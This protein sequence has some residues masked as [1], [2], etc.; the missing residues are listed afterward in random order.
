MKVLLIQPPVQ[1]F[2]DTDVRLQPI[3]LA[4]LKAAVKKHLSEVE[5][6]IKD[7]HGG[8]GR[9]TVPIPKELRYLSDYY[10]VADKSPFSTFHQFYHFGKSFDEI[11]VEV[12]ELKPDVVGISSLFTPYFREALEVAARVKKRTNA[13]VVLGGSH[14]SAAPKSLLSSPNVDYVIRG[15]GEKAFVEFLRYLLNRKS[16]EDVPNLAYKHQDNI[17][18]NPIAD[19]FPIDALP[20]PDL[21]DFAPSTYTLAG[22]AM[23]FMITSRSCPH[24]CSFCSVHITFG[25]DYRRRSLE[26][27]LEEIELR[28]QQGY[29]VID[30]EDDNLTYYKNTFKELCRRLIARFPSREMEYVAMNGI[31]YLSLDDELLELMFRAGFTN[32]NL[33]LVSSDKTVRE[34]TKRPH[35]L[36]AYVR[37][38]AKAHQLGFKIVSYQIL[39]LPNE[40]L[41]S[42]IQTLAF[43][44]RLPVLLG[45]SPF[46]RTPNAPIARGIDLNEDDFVKARFTALAIETDN[47]SRDDIYTLFVTTRIINFFKG[48]STTESV[49]LL[50]L[51]THPWP[52]S[53]TRT[54]FEL[55][56]QLITTGFLY[57]R[58]KAGSV[59]NKKFNA[60]LFRRVLNQAGEV[61]AQNGGKIILD[62]FARTLSNHDLARIS[63]TVIRNV[64]PFELVSNQM[65]PS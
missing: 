7:Y 36:E 9:R 34:T 21:S 12:A 42:M 48:L 28:Y 38:V 45:A 30:F 1:D 44:A 25:T 40:S 10:S 15:E 16:L 19:N 29:R 24:K 55:M 52:D 46:Y 14:A 65:L 49:S 33:A 32:L 22:K 5:V 11:E 41:E 54:G 17:V 20:I 8:C 62:E 23:T 47:F 58:S 64:A 61:S 37:V 43:N 59:E 51:M 63:G 6:I 35:T 31:S 53:R 3:G 56:R 60:D 27:V 13:I 4:Y 39:G 57:A 2:Y 18:L 50:D 26:N